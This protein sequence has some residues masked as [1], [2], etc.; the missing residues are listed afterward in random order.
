MQ[1]QL[2]TLDAA[3]AKKGIVMGI[4]NKKKY[5][6][7]IR[8]YF[9]MLLFAMCLTMNVFFCGA[10]NR[11]ELLDQ[12]TITEPWAISETLIAEEDRY[13]TADHLFVTADIPNRISL[14][15]F[16]IIV[17]LYFFLTLFSILPDRW[18]LINQK[19]RLNN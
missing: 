13:H 10:Y 14:F 18:T 16:L 15:L 3:V 5:L 1:F 11:C 8:V 4:N 17:Y 19:V 12:A 2:S 7:R 9:M 6:S